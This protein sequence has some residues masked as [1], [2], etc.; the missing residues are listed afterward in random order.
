MV[1]WPEWSLWIYDNGDSE[2]VMKVCLEI[3]YEARRIHRARPPAEIGPSGSQFH[4]HTIVF[5]STKFVEMK[6]KKLFAPRT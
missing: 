3:G 5:G 2:L 1:I 4:N 6:Q